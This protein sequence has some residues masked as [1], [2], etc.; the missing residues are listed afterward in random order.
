M[1][2]SRSPGARA[3]DSVLFRGDQNVRALNNR[4]VRD[5]LQLDGFIEVM[6]RKGPAE[7]HLHG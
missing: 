5:A 6:I 4:L 3:I 7:D 1:G 2:L